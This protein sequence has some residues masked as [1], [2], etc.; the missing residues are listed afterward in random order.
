MTH[1]QQRWMSE[2]E[3]RVLEAA[4]PEGLTADMRAVT[5]CL[6]EAL[7]LVDERAG[8][9]APDGQW[10]AQLQTWAQQACMQLQHL[11]DQMGG[12]ATYLAKGVAVH[13][14]ARDREMC[15][16]FKGNNYRDL[17]LEYSLTEMRVRQI[18]DAWQRTNYAQ[19]QGVLAI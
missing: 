6:Y 12:R 2:A 19:R 11:A 1:P 9:T 18:V 13:L 14:S 4:L 7:V 16:K 10:L 3:A 8:T 17:A 15:S 5:M